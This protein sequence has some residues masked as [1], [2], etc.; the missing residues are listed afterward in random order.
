[1]DEDTTVRYDRFVKTYDE[2][3]QNILL[4]R[5]TKAINPEILKLEGKW[6]R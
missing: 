3:A 4:T 5:I 2:A 1:M 6:R